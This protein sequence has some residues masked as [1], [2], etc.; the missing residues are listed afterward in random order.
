MTITFRKAGEGG[1]MGTVGATPG[2]L[3]LTRGPQET[4]FE[5]G[6]IVVIHASPRVLCGGRSWRVSVGQGEEHSVSWSVGQDPGCLLLPLDSPGIVQRLPKCPSSQSASFPELQTDGCT[7][8][9]PGS[10]SEGH[11]LCMGGHTWV[12]GSIYV[13]SMCRG[14]WPVLT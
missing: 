7:E 4:G 12:W 3:A 10:G 6:R 2:C 1:D 11:P 8:Q 9:L 5:P 14:E 13:V